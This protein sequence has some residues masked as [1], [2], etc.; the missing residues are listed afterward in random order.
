M[1]GTRASV[2]LG[3]SHFFWSCYPVFHL[4]WVILSKSSCSGNQHHTYSSRFLERPLNLPRE[5]PPAALWGGQVF[6]PKRIKNNEGFWELP[7]THLNRAWFSEVLPAAYPQ[8]HPLPCGSTPAHQRNLL[9]LKIEVYVL[10]QPLAF[11]YANQ[12]VVG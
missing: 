8:N 5:V 2:Y 3:T 6:L 11:A 7:G 12:M 4:L 1:S 10:V 9:L